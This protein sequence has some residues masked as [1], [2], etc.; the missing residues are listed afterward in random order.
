MDETISIHEFSNS[1]VVCETD[2]WKVTAVKTRH[3]EPY[4]LTF[5]YRI[6]SE[7]GSVVIAEDTSPTQEVR[8]LA[9]EADLLVHECTAPEEFLRRYGFDKHHT[10]PKSV[11]RL[12]TEAKVKKL[13]V[14]HFLPD[15]DTPETISKMEQVIRSDY[16]GDLFM[17]I[18]GL[19]VSVP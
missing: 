16:R 11:A 17:G 1:G 8:E 13:V 14:T 18:D 9:N 3:V 2:R 7:D 10:G 12:A 4:M 5:A 15:I 19:R 6:D